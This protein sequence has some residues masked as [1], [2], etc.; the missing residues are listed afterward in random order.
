LATIRNKHLYINSR[1][2]FFLLMCLYRIRIG[3]I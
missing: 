3:K 2:V 1:S